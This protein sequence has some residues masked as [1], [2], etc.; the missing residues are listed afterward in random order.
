VY[1][2]SIEFEDHLHKRMLERDNSGNP[3]V[4]FSDAVG[5]A[6]RDALLEALRKEFNSTNPFG[7][8]Y[9]LLTTSE[10]RPWVKSLTSADFPRLSV[11]S[12]QELTA[13]MQLQVI[14]RISPEVSHR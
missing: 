3:G 7:P 1:V 8:M 2:L 5:D 9:P 11:L 14:G 13:D 12:Y 4:A 10:I 6:G